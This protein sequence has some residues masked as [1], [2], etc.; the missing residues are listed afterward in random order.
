MIM[1]N[2]FFQTKLWIR[3]AQ[4]WGSYCSSLD[5]WVKG[6]ILAETKKQRDF[7]KVTKVINSDFPELKETRQTSIKKKSPPPTPPKTKLKDKVPPECWTV[8]IKVFKAVYIFWIF[9]LIEENKEWVRA[10]EILDR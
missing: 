1:N 6:K 10:M 8:A 5:A 2:F 4:Y 3:Q 7:T 9:N